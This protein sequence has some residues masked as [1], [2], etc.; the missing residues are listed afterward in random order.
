MQ[1][2]SISGGEFEKTLETNQW[3]KRETKPKMKWV[4][5][6]R[7]VFDKMMNA[8]YD[9]T[10]FNLS[11]DSVISKSDFVFHTDDTMRFE[12]KKYYMSKFNDWIMYSEPFFKVSTRDMLDV[13]DRDK[14][15]KFVDDFM[16]HRQDILDRVLNDI[17]NSNLGIRCIDGFISQDKLEFKIEKRDGWEGYN[18]IT[19]VAK[20]K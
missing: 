14:Y 3:I 18:R 13:V 1:K 16:V 11:E 20:L 17:T 7:N 2:R 12:A 6:G 19:I 10:K 8:G 4:G 5:K 15:N 9:V